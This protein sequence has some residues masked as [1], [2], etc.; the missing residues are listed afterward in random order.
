MS[1]KDIHSEIITRISKLT[2]E[3]PDCEDVYD[4]QYTCT[5]CFSQGGN[6]N[7]DVLEYL[8]NVGLF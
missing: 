5:T 8:E 1:K 3:C 6:G 7:I 2:V 4:D